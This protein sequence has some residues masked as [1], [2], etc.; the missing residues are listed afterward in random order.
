MTSEAVIGTHKLPRKYGTVKWFGGRNNKTGR[1]N[2][3]GFVEDVGG[4]DVFLHKREWRGT[5]LPHE[6]Q[7]LTYLEEESGGKSSARHA[8]PLDTADLRAT[9]LYAALCVPPFNARGFFGSGLE[10]KKLLEDRL[11]QSLRTAKP[12]DLRALVRESQRDTAPCIFSLVAGGTD[13]REN[14]ALLLEAGGLRITDDAP[15]AA[16]SPSVASEHESTIAAHLRNLKPDAARAK[17]S[18]RLNILPPSLLT[19]L[20]TAGV[21]TSTEQLGKAITRVYDYIVSVSVKEATAFPAYLKASFDEDSTNHG[22]QPSNPILRAILDNL[23]FKKSL[24]E[25]S[26]KFAEIYEKSTRLR[27]NVDT[28]T[29]Y[30]LVA[31]II[32]GNERDVVYSVFMQRL[33]EALIASKSLSLKQRKAQL[34]A[35]F[36]PC[37]TMGPELSCEAVHWPK[38]NMFLCRG[39]TCSSPEVL[40][41]PG[42]HF[43]EFNIYD[44]LNHYGIDYVTSGKPETKDFPIKLASYFNRLREILS[45][46]HCRECGDLMLPNMKYGRTQ[47]RELIDGVVEV[48]EMAAVY[49]LT[50]FHCNSDH[51]GEFNVDYYISHCVGFGC[52]HIIDS[53]DLKQRCSHGRYICR[54]CGGCCYEHAQ[55]HPA[56]QCVECGSELEVWSETVLGRQATYSQ[57]FVRCT[58]V[59]CTFKIAAD[60]LPAKFSRLPAQNDSDANSLY[61]MS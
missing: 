42:R 5:R 31:L 30:H 15:W 38:R 41:G 1:E 34:H 21:F 19:Y 56:G 6:D 24:F 54:G 47:Y 8:E 29:L 55:S 12:E 9:E 18:D 57:K 37:S 48:K 51:C 46:L 58:S 14:Y 17:C 10:V 27:R 20:L 39:K 28:F 4:K 2:S 23:Q 40:P 25:K 22:G 3:F 61:D 13:A 11:R 53:R 44:W 35:L 26:T 16:L 50:V 59:D 32:A 45:T 7:L 49:R 36:P 43:M 52:Y 33:W 60:D